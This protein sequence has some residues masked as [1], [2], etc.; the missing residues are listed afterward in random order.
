MHTPF[1]LLFN[2]LANAPQAQAPL[3]ETDPA[4]LEF[5]DEVV[6]L[7]SAFSYRVAN[8]FEAGALIR[9]FWAYADGDLG[10]D[11]NGFGFNDVDIW[12]EM[13]LDNFEFRV[14]FDASTG[15]TIL[16]DAYARWLKSESLEVSFGNFKP[17]TLF[18]ATVDP[19]HLVLNDRTILGT[20]FDRW[21]LG[22]GAA[23]DIEKLGYFVSVTNGANG[24]A[25]NTLLV[26]RAEFRV[27]GEERVPLQEGN[28]GLEEQ[29]IKIGAVYYSDTGNEEIGFG[30]DALAR[31][32]RYGGL[33]EYMRFGDGLSGNAVFPFL[34]VSLVPDSSPFTATGWVNL[35]DNF[36][37]AARYQ[38]SDN[39]DALDIVGGGLTFF[40]EDLPM[41]ITADANFYS[42]DT[43][44]GF[45]LQ[46]GVTVGHWRRQR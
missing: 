13:D 38:S 44:D 1:L 30:I 28:H 25:D 5:T 22:V 23:G 26:A 11:F 42:D 14:N 7:D 46:I 9:A 18:S 40:P 20:L 41:A 36:Q 31:A 2:L 27:H 6:L 45:A 10:Q 34:T 4:A 17:N 24:P 35:D 21:D 29:E 33:V 32:E 16:E 19:D 8:D 37:I 12:A 3:L 39:N 15:T 43:N